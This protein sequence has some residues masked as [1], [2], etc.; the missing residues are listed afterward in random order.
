[1]NV[2]DFDKTII[3]YDSE[4]LFI[5]FVYRRYPRLFFKFLPKTVVGAFGYV[6]NRHAEQLKEA[7]FSCLPYIP[8]IDGLLEQF[9]DENEWRVEDYYKKI[10][11]YDDLVISASP[12]FLIKPMCNRLYVEFLGTPMSVSTGNIQ[13]INCH[14]EEKVR[15]FRELYPYEEVDEFYSDS[16]SDTPMAKIAKKAFL[17]VNHEPVPWPEDILKQ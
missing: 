9:W 12:E 17:I 15:R 10:R 14:G 16:L 11:R 3:N 1:M 13:G 6:K 4:Y 2:F 5:P 7:L 8:D